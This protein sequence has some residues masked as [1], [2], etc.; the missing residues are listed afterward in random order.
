[1]KELHLHFTNVSNAA[2]PRLRNM[3]GL[4]SLQMVSVTN[5][6]SE[7]N[8]EN[9]APLQSLLELEKLDLFWNGRVT[10][11]GLAHIAGLTKLHSLRL[12]G[13]EELSDAGIAR[14]SELSGLRALTLFISDGDIDGNLPVLDLL[15]NLETLEVNCA[16][17]TPSRIAAL[18]GRGIE[19]SDPTR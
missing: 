10:D 6:I 15:P 5:S 14:L 16:T 18:R 3:T 13:N 1:M 4:R 2:L 8:G 7:V 17:M 9:L 12:S 11:P 19:V